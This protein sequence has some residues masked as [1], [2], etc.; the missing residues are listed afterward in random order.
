MIEYVCVFM[1]DPEFKK[2]ILIRKEKPEWQKGFLNGVGGKVEKNED[3]IH[4]AMSREFLEETGIETL[5]ND[6]TVYA[7]ITGPSSKTLIPDYRV[8]FFFTTNEK[9]NDYVTM[10]EELVTCINVADLQ[11]HKT[12]PN[13]QWLIPMAIDN[14]VKIANIQTL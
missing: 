7:T 13:L 12:I 10:E 14:Q 9:Y 3:S 11:N 1:F 6:W 8:Y 4:D 2:V 5:S